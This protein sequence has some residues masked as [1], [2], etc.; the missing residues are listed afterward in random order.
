M[1]A[2]FEPCGVVTLL[3]DFGV[4]D[5][6][7]G[8]MKGVVLSRAPGATV[9]DLTH[10]VPPQAVAV[11][12]WHLSRSAPYFPAGTVHVA[13]VDPGVGSARRVLCARDRG[14]A[15]L[16]PDNGLLGPVLSDAA[17][18]FALDVER[19]ALPRR[20]ST[21]HGRDVFA[22]AAAALA[23]GQDPRETG[24]PAGEWERLAL[25]EPREGPDGSLVVPVLYADRFGNLI[26]TFDP[27]NL[28]D[29]VAGLTVVAGGRAVPI[30]TTYAD[31]ER[32]E[33]LALVGSSGTLEVSVR[34]GDAARE[35]ALGA[36]STLVLRRQLR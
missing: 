9:V 17:E 23:G 19:Y 29:G 20:S 11:G 18:V 27:S 7:V 26:T 32:G 8:V 5:P 14:Q 36:G 28:E 25:P 34:D 10:G 21:F 35:L 24:P 12:A 15:F 2:P 13:V 30:V 33:A 1:S 16:A 6:Y 3:S 4:V 22:P 31:V